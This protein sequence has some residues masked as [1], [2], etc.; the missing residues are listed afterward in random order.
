MHVK[1]KKKPKAGKFWFN[2]WKHFVKFTTKQGDIKA[3]CNHCEG[4]YVAHPKTIG[5]FGLKGH[6]IIC[7][8]MKNSIKKTKARRTMYS[9]IFMRD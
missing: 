3:R 6:L 9:K 2:I 1:V 7:K 4:E 5:T 8:V